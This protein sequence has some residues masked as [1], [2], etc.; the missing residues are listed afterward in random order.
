MAPPYFITIEGPEGSGK[1]TQARLLTDVLNN[2][3][4]RTMLTREPGG[5]PISEKIREIL[6]YADDE[7]VTNRGELLLYLAAR[8]EH[9]DRVI[10]PNLAEGISIVCD[11]YIDSTLA[12][13]G[14]GNGTDLDLIRR[15]NDF[16]TGGL[17]P[18]ITILLDIDVEIGLRRQHEWNRIERRALEFHRKVREGFQKEAKIH[19]DRIVMLDASGDIESTWRK[20]IDIL[21]DRLG[22]YINS[23]LEAGK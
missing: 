2:S 3:G 4:Y 19:P 10:R 20:I 8:A 12:Y 6:L 1:T 11:R 18:H 16:A 22:L 23:T 5:D 21:V 9:T 13:Q 17:L 15:L 14:Y 7:S